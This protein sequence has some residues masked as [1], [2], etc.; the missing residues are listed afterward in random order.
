MYEVT[1]HY[2]SLDSAIPVR[3]TAVRRILRC[4]QFING[5]G[6][7]EKQRNTDMTSLGVHTDRLQVS[8][9]GFPLK[10]LRY[11]TSSDYEKKRTCHAPT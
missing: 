4:V 6:N 2:V 1:P 5:R 11:V 9:H 3:P 10:R 7:L 8:R